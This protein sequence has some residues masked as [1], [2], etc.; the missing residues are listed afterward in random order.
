MDGVAWLLDSPH[1]FVSGLSH[2]HMEAQP[3]VR[4]L[5]LLLLLS[6]SRII[7]AAAVAAT[8]RIILLRAYVHHESIYF[9]LNQSSNASKQKLSV[10]YLDE[11][12]QV[13]VASPEASN[14]CVALGSEAIQMLLVPRIHCSN[15]QRRLLENAC[16]QT[17]KNRMSER[18][19]Y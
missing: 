2:I 8:I 16:E 7:A 12:L 9:H 17:V 5:Q 18:A 3:R 10:Q 14:L 11:L 19:A 6:G 13:V 4:P 1:S 15:S